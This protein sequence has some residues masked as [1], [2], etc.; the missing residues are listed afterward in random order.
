MARDALWKTL[1][2]AATGFKT[3][4][5]PPATDIKIIAMKNTF[6]AMRCLD[7]H[8]RVNNAAAPAR[9][10]TLPAVM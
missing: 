6:P 4:K 3:A 9:N 5:T 7:D 10:P 2:A 1:K 8:F